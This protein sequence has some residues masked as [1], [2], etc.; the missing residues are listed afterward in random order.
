MRVAEGIRSLNVEPGSLCIIWLGQ[1]GFVFKTAGGQLIFVDAY[2]SDICAGLPGG[3]IAGKRIVP[4]PLEA[5]EIMSGTW[6]ATHRHEDHLD[7]ESVTII[8]RNAPNV[9]FAGPASCIRVLKEE[10][11]VPPDR[12]HLL[13]AGEKWYGDGFSLHTVYAYHGENEPDAVGIVLESDGIRVYHT[14]DTSYCPERM[15][16]VIGLEP[17][18]IIPCINGTFGNMDGIEAARLAN[19]VG[20]RV[21]IPCHFWFFVIQNTNPDGTPATFLEACAVHARDTTPVLLT[22]GEP[23][24]HRNDR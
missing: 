3:A 4:A 14:G 12:T 16:E 11:A 1:A 24:V 8:A 9:H 23:Y 10:L 5:R 7:D 18:I 6:I 15:E 17:D 2:L 20:A 13:A 22:I 19:D 21:A